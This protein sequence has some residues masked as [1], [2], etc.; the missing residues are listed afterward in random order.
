MTRNKPLRGKRKQRL[1][2]GEGLFAKA[3]PAPAPW[4]VGSAADGRGLTFQELATW[5]G[6][7][8]R[9][10]LTG[11]HVACLSSVSLRQS[12]PGPLSAERVPTVPTVAGRDVEKL[13]DTQLDWRIDIC[14][15]ASP[16]GR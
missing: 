7:S 2:A 12:R 15:L 9:G 8:P 4:G 3:L 13:T 1:P 14:E 10:V 11:F 6:G 5:E 16:A